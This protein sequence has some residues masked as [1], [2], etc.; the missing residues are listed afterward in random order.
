MAKKRYISPVLAV[1]V[2]NDPIIV[3]GGSQ[4]TGGYDSP[5]R[6]SGIDDATLNLIELICDDIDLADMDANGDLEITYDEYL[7]W[8]QKNQPW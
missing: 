5:Y 7:A 4:G 1:S 6:F 3:I 8:Y 2:D